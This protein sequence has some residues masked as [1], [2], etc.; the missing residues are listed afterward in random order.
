MDEDTLDLFLAIGDCHRLM[1]V[2]ANEVRAR[3]NVTDVTHWSDMYNVDGAFRL[4]EFV[5]AEHPDGQATSWRLEL[6]LTLNNV[7]VEA[8]VRRIHGSGQDLL[9][10]IVDCS[11]GT[12]SECSANLLEITRRLCAANS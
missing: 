2:H 8:D 9:T 7:S 5:D 11:Y 12:A 6:T 1:V 4:E 3:L 10:E